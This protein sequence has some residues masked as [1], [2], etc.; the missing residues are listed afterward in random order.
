[1]VRNVI[2]DIGKVMIEFDWDTFLRRYFD[3]RTADAVAAATWGSKSWNELDRGVLPY[4]E[5]MEMFG[6]EDTRCSDQI[7]FA[8]KHVDECPVMQSYAVPWVDELK[9][10]GY[11][12]YYLSNYFEYLLEKRPDVLEFTKHMDG[13]IFSCHEKLIKPDERIYRRLCEKYSLIPEECIFIDDSPKNIRGAEQF[14]MKGFLFEGYDKSYSVITDYLKS[15][16]IIDHGS[17]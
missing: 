1:M 8:M 17:E 4:D 14:G 3:D 9:K 16:C 7:I 12:V 13:G 15:D 10:Q 11:H 2:F 6:R 5:V